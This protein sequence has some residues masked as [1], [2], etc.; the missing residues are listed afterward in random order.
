MLDKFIA[1]P[2]AICREATT[3]LTQLSLMILKHA[4]PA[5]MLKDML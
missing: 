1:K 5:G 4:P 2:F 3:D